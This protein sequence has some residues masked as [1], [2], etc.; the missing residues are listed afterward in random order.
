MALDEMDGVGPETEDGRS[1]EPGVIT[2]RNIL[3]SFTESQEVRGLI[4][5]LKGVFGDLVTREMTMEKFIGEMVDFDGI[6]KPLLKKNL[7]V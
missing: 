4:G 3:E 1:Q 2:T 5:N 6:E 7:V